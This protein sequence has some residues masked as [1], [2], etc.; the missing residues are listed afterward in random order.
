MGCYRYM[1]LNL[2]DYEPKPDFLGTY[3]YIYIPRINQKW[4][5]IGICT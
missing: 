4:A 5:V 1:Y 2:P 3:T